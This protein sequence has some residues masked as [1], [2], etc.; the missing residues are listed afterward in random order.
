MLTELMY[1]NSSTVRVIVVINLLAFDHHDV[2]T[3]SLC[4]NTLSTV[5]FLWAVPDNAAVGCTLI[6][7]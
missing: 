5:R 2:R 4:R 3:F 7:S 1:V 6:R